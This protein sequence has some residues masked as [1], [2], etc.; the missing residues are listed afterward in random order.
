MSSSK[1]HN[2]SDLQVLFSSVEQLVSH[3]LLSGLG[4]C[5]AVVVAS[6]GE[7]Y[8][9]NLSSSFRQRHGGGK[10]V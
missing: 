3:P 10:G 4:L 1:R 7:G 9:T 6:L 5:D 2:C 8:L